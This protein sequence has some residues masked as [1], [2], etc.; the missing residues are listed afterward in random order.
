MIDATCTLCYYSRKTEGSWRK[1][2][3]EYKEKTRYVSIA[4]CTFNHFLNI[5]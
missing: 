4:I 3:Q 1:C 5:C 2:G